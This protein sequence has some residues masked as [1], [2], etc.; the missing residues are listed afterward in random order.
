MLFVQDEEEK[1][2]EQIQKGNA[3]EVIGRNL[4]VDLFERSFTSDLKGN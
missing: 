2:K 1:R 3:Q 4:E